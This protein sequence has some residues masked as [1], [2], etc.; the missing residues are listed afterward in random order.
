M[1]D[2]P[3]LV[4][5]TGLIGSAIAAALRAQGAQVTCADADV[6][7]AQAVGTPLGCAAVELDIADAA[8]AAVVVRQARPAIIVHAAGRFNAGTRDE[9]RRLVLDS[10]RGTACL[11]AAATAGGVGRLLLVSSLAVYANPRGRLLETSRTGGTMP[12]GLAKSAAESALLAGCA[13]TK[14]TP[15]IARL[16]GV[17]GGAATAGGWLN[18]TLHGLVDTALRGDEV[19]IP[20]FLGGHEYLH[21]RDA[22]AGAMKV[23]ENGRAGPYNIGT[24][25]PLDAAA[26]ASA[27]ATLGAAVTCEEEADQARLWWLD[28]SKARAELGFEAGISLAD[29]LRIWAAE[30]TA[31]RARPAQVTARR[32]TAGEI[33]REEVR[34]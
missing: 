3:I 31:G 5:G 1:R 15:L 9:A 20:A 4:A 12:Y 27:F 24:S 18:T 16:S 23:A 29:G 13:G 33:T 7:R 19:R 22:A 21:I 30:I 34:Q 2:V 28:T 14:T 10:A 17:Y 11:T 32:T 8:R 25:S 26:V 6:A